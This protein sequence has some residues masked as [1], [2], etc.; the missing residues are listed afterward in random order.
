MCCVFDMINPLLLT[1]PPSVIDNRHVLASES[2]RLKG[3]G[4]TSHSVVL[5]TS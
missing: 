4:P 1:T 3:M 5:F 2:A